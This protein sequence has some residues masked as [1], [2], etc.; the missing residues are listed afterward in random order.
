MW[1]AVLKQELTLQENFAGTC[2]TIPAGTIWA[3]KKGLVDGV[4]GVIASHVDEAVKYSNLYL[5][6]KEAQQ[7]FTRPTKNL[8]SAYNQSFEVS[9]AAYC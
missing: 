4:Q 9:E 2:Y 8:D 3:V 7:L 5:L 1:Y 6:T